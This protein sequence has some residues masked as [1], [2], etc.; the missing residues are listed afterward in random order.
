MSKNHFTKE[1]ID[2][3]MQNQYIKKVT[4]K[5]ITY[6]DSFKEIFI[7]ENESGKVPR[8]IFKEYGFDETIITK[9]RIENCG[10]RWRKLK[11]EDKETGLSDTRG[12]PLE[13][14]LSEEENI[15]RLKTK[16]AYLT[17]ENQFLKELNRIERGSV[18]RT[19]SQQKKNSL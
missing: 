10:K 5:S 15:E 2:I 9:E 19:N 17:A 14:E 3:L 13:R 16:I 11:K 6:T 4:E 18:R 1:Q 7:R 8:Q 12:R